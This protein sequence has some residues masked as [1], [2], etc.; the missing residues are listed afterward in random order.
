[1][2]AT[3]S[4]KAPPRISATVLRQNVYNILDEVLATG[5]PVEVERKG[6]ILRI[7]PEEVPSRLA[8]LTTHDWVVGDIDDLVHID[9][10]SEWSELKEP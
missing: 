1:M 6:R 7:V 9:W 2:K 8:G 10:S 3:G 5:Q 4:A